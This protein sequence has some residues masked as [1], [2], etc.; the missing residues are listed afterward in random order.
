VEFRRKP[1]SSPARVHI[2]LGARSDA[3]RVIGKTPSVRLQKLI[4]GRVAS[5]EDVGYTGG[6]AGH[7]THVN[8]IP[9]IVSNS[10]VISANGLV[11][12]PA[13]TQWNLHFGHDSVV[14]FGKRYA[15]TMLE[16]LDW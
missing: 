9:G 16:A 2:P 15:Q 10:F 8:R 14:E 5:S 7:N 3:A 11:V 6:T 1:E 12:D 4:D 13:D